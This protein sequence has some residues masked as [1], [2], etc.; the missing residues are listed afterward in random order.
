MN[1]LARR[2]AR[3]RSAGA[4]DNATWR[5]SG[6][7]RAPRACAGIGDVRRALE[8]TEAQDRWCRRERINGYPGMCRLF[9]SDVKRLHGAWPEAEAE[10]RQASAELQGFLPGAAGVALYQIGEIRL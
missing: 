5:S 4:C 2:R 3:W 7:R 9:R 1:P 10:A 8:W 6:W